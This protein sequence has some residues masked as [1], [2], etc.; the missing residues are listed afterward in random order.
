MKLVNQVCR[1]IEKLTGVS[2]SR[3]CRRFGKV[4]QLLECIRR[5]TANQRASTS[6]CMTNDWSAR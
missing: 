5:E 6:R 2:S 4:S 3:T 1:R